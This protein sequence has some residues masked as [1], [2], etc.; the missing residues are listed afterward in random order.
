MPYL[1]VTGPACWLSSIAV[2]SAIVAIM[3]DSATCL[4]GFVWGVVI[5]GVFSALFGVLQ[6]LLLA[7]CGRWIWNVLRRQRT[8]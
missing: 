4:P 6:I 8:G 2:V 3:G 7:N 5:A 1:Y